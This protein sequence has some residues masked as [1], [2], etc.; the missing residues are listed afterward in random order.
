MLPCPGGYHSRCLSTRRCFLHGSGGRG[1]CCCGCDCGG[2]VVALAS[3]LI[4]WAVLCACLQS[5]CRS[6]RKKA[7]T[8]CQISAPATVRFAVH[9]PILPHAPC[10]LFFRLCPGFATV[11]L[12]GAL[13]GRCVRAC[14]Y[15]L[16][17]NSVTCTCV[18]ACVHA[19]ACV[20]WSVCFVVILRCTDVFLMPR[21]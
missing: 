3:V 20:G 9:V 15:E 8:H 1:C 7:T 18:R 14:V 19:C 12:V 17:K 6:R 2:A 21:R 11:L 4:G 10:A 16:E 13:C 5:A